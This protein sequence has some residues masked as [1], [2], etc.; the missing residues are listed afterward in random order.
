[1]WIGNPGFVFQPQLAAEEEDHMERVVE[2]VRLYRTRAHHVRMR[3]PRRR[4]LQCER[5]RLGS[6]TDHRTA[7][8]RFRPLRSQSRQ[9]HG[10]EAERYRTATSPE[11]E[12]DRVLVVVQHVACDGLFVGVL[13]LSS[14]L[15]GNREC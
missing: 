10:H 12:D 11:N 7:R 9:L 13:L 6:E 15:S 3:L 2:D 1:M 4:V 5:Q 8:R 14:V